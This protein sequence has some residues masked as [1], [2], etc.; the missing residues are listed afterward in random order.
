MDTT[1]GTW[2]YQLDTGI[3]HV[4][5]LWREDAA[6]AVFPAVH[7]SYLEILNLHYATT[8]AAD[9][10]VIHYAVLGSNMLTLWPTPSAVYTIKLFY[11][12]RPTAMSDG[13]HD[14]SNITY[15]RIPTEFH[16]AIEY[17]ALWQ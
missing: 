1:A 16:K 3:L 6:G 15:G 14:P 13:T 9:S 11:V 12:P 2:D 5:D 8:A 7:D 17:Y 10:N 4:K